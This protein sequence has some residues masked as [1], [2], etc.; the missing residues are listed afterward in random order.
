LGGSKEDR[1]TREQLK[2]VI[3]STGVAI[4]NHEVIGESGVV[5]HLTYL[6]YEINNYLTDNGLYQEYLECMSKLINNLEKNK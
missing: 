1:M 5:M 2:K 3:D 4:N 6:S